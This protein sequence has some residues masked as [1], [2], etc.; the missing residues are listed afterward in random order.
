MDKDSYLKAQVELARPSFYVPSVVV[1][2]KDVEL[3]KTSLQ[4]VTDE[5]SSAYRTKK[6]AGYSK[7]CLQ[8]FFEEFYKKLFELCPE[9]KPLFANTDMTEQGGKVGAMLAAAL[10]VV[11]DDPITCKSVLTKLAKDHS[12]YGV[13]AEYYGSVGLSVVLSLKLVLGEAMDD[14]M[15]TAWVRVYSVILD[16]VL[17]VACE[18]DMPTNLPSTS[19]S[20]SSCSTSLSLNHLSS[21]AQN[22]SIALPLSLIL[23]SAVAMIVFRQRVN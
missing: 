19:S 11:Y 4:L 23:I 2:P 5:K 3:A 12:G 9:A 14:D 17:P 10:G 22:L 6:L 8:W 18:C 13:K 15:F 20:S 16:V 7:T 1:T 21:K